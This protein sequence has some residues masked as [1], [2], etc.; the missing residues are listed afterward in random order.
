M[1]PEKA[2]FKYLS[3]TIEYMYSTITWSYFSV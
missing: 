1:T 2:V 3:V